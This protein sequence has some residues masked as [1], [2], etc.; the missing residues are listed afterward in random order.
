MA[1][2]DWLQLAVA[3]VGGGVLGQIGKV[4]LERGPRAEIQLRKDLK[5]WNDTLQATNERQQALIDH[6]QRE[7]L[8]CE[9][10]TGILELQIQRLTQ[11]LSPVIDLPE[12]T[13]THAIVAQSVTQTLVESDQ[14]SI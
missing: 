12:I 3:A 8:A 4:V 13:M 7:T 9:K 11:A 6:L 1:A 10:R 5:E 2:G 14:Q